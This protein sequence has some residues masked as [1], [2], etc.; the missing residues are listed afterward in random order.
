M[1]RYRYGVALA[2][3][4]LILSACSSPQAQP[5]EMPF[6]TTPMVVTPSPA[7]GNTDAYPYPYPAPS[8]QAVADPAYPGP[9][10]PVD[11]TGRAVQA[12]AALPLALSDAQA[13]FNPDAKLY[14]ILPSQVMIINLGSPPVLPGWYYKFKVDGSPREYIVQVVNDVVTGTQEV[15][16]IQPPDPPELEI[17]PATV[18]VDSDQ[19]F[20]SFAEK[21][22]SLGITVDDPKGYDLELVNLE[23]G[24]GPVWSVFDP[25]T[26]RWL[27]SVS[28]TSGAEVENP[29]G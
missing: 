26:Q 8:V 19:V 20:A 18:T 2:L 23:G 22:P 27:Y 10:G 14:A 4:A 21:A 17:D 24:L 1:T 11:T 3:S 28:G 25:A 5:T 13:N 12:L 9:E 7:Q 16:P 29:R 6:Q 15:E